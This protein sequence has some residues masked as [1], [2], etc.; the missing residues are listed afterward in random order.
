MLYLI[1]N[2]KR[3][4]AIS[5]TESPVLRLSHVLQ[6]QLFATKTLFVFPP[7]TVCAGTDSKEMVT[8]AVTVG[9]LS[10]PQYEFQFLLLE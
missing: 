10:H 8:V 7:D 2:E 6:I 1:L 9:Y 3:V 5:E 4:Q